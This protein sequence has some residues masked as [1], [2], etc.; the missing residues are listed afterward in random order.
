MTAKI[1]SF[2]PEKLRCI[3]VNRAAGH[4]PN[5]VCVTFSR[6]LTEAELDLLRDVI[7]RSTALLLT[8][9]DNPE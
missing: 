7:L 3:S 8:D 2:T 9:D 1:V 5:S 6:T 4:V